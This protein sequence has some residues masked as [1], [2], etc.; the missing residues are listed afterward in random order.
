MGRQLRETIQSSILCDFFDLMHFN[1]VK[2]MKMLVFI[3]VF[4]EPN[5]FIEDHGKA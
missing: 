5:V 1:D 2:R 3:G 4:P